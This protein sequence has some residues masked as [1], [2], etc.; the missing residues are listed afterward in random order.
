MLQ[1]PSKRQRVQ[2]DE[3]DAAALTTAYGPS[4]VVDETHAGFGVVKDTKPLTLSTISG[5]RL[6]KIGCILFINYT[7]GS[8]NETTTSKRQPLG[9]WA[10]SCCRAPLRTAVCVKIGAQI[11][12]PSCRR[13]IN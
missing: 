12:T 9:T 6:A 1:I 4:V 5:V 11:F 13:L 10:A 7:E 8:K 2:H 3:V